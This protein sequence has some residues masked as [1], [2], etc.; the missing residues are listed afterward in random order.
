VT[1]ATALI[2]GIV[3]Q[4]QTNAGGFFPGATNSGNFLLTHP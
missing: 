2:K 3:F 4:E 1:S